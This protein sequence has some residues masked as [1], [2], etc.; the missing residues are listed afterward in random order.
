MSFIKLIASPGVQSFFKVY[1]GKP[2]IELSR[3]RA[4]FNDRY[5]KY[6]EFFH[7]LHWWFLLSHY[8]QCKSDG[9]WEERP[10]EILACYGGRLLMKERVGRV[11]GMR[12]LDRAAEKNLTPELKQMVEDILHKLF[13][14]EGS[15][16]LPE[17]VALERFKIWVDY[18]SGRYIWKL[19]HDP[20]FSGYQL[21]AVG[22]DWS[23]HIQKDWIENGKWKYDQR[24]QRRLRRV[25][26]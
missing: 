5:V 2:V 6:H 16:I 9:N 1:R 21:G 13:A 26:K 23:E 17:L 18:H 19:F 10:E 22:Q 7:F 3:R 25:Q 12:D 8:N 11:F 15:L 14:H 4:Y 24:R 20:D